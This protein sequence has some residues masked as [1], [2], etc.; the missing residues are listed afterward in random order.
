MPRKKP[1]STTPLDSTDYHT[2]PPPAPPAVP[3]SRKA[4]ILNHPTIISLTSDHPKFALVQSILQQPPPIPSPPPISP[5]PTPQPRTTPTRA[6]K[7]KRTT[8]IDHLSLLPFELINLIIEFLPLSS[9][10]SVA[11]LNHA[12][13]DSIY[14]DVFDFLG[15]KTYG[16]TYW[17]ELCAHMAPPPPTNPPPFPLTKTPKMPPHFYRNVLKSQRNLSDYKVQNSPGPSKL[18]PPKNFFEDFVLRFKFSG[19]EESVLVTLKFDDY[20]GYLACEF[21]AASKS[22]F[23]SITAKIQTD[24]TKRAKYENSHPITLDP[25]KSFEHINQNPDDYD[26]QQFMQVYLY[27]RKLQKTVMIFDGLFVGVVGADDTETF[28]VDTTEFP[29]GDY[30]KPNAI[31]HKIVFSF[32][33][34]R[35]PAAADGQTMTATATR[36]GAG[37]DNVR[38]W[39][40]QKE[41]PREFVYKVSERIRASLVEK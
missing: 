15:K 27:H 24:L 32:T 3:T 5:R 37:I 6:V 8:T 21:S 34:I 33:Y 19:C 20:Y 40:M 12:I 16:E 23:N 30:I 1:F 39:L 25:L 36:L 11:S 14:D 13:A 31:A 38:P 18:P 10:P 7:K 17:F 26:L 9:L 4:T 41:D 29:F 22:L 35:A 2:L 28:A